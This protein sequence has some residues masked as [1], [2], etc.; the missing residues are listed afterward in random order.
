MNPTKKYDR[1]RASGICVH[2]NKILLIHRINLELEKGKQ[3][4]YVILGGGVEDGEKVEDAVIRE[5]KEETSLDVTLGELFYE[6]EDYDGEGT[7]LKYY[8]YICE[9]ISGEVK[10]EENSIE[11]IEMKDG[12]QFFKPEWVPLSVVKDIVLYPAPVK[13]EILTRYTS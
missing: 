10:L 5:M 7:F 13:T 1:I 2:D 6:L 3:E 9:C 8:A 4:Y 12:L 11:A